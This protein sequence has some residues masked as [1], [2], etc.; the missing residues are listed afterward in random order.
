[1]K[2]LE[3]ERDSIV[4]EEEDNLKNYYD[5]LNQYKS[6]KKDIRDIVLSPRYC[7]PFLQPGRL[8][9]IECNSNDE[10]SSTFS[11]KDQVT[12]GLIINFQKVKGV[13]EGDVSIISLSFMFFYSNFSFKF[14]SDSEL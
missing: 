11:I 3:E 9:S 2:S 10:I 6:L 7:L 4:I 12:W 5:L 8:V 14:C 1:M 13:S